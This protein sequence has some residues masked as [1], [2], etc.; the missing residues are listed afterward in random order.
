MKKYWY[1]VFLIAW[2]GAGCLELPKW[3]QEKP[4][5][6]PSKPAAPPQAKR[7][8][9]LVGP[10]QVNE[11]NAHKMGMRLMDELDHDSQPPE[12]EPPPAK[13]AK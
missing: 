11:A 10:E 8:T 4:P 6:P 7:P 2:T 5:A 9:T 12:D 3:H 13:P 1:L